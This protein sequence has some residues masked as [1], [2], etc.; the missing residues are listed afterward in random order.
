MKTQSIHTFLKNDLSYC[1]AAVLLADSHTKHVKNH[2]PT[3][4]Q[5][6]Y[7]IKMTTSNLFKSMKLDIMLFQ[8]KDN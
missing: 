5:K 2:F 1:L 4:E 6:S 8:N 3:L 7:F